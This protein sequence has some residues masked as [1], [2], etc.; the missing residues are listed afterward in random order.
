ML[1]CFAD[2]P[3]SVVPKSFFYGG[4]G[5]DTSTSGLT[6]SLDL[7]THTFILFLMLKLFL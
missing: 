4:A 5:A 1:G 7:F 2:N 3:S 6:P